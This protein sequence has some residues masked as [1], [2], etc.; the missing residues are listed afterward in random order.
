MQAKFGQRLGY[1]QLLANYMPERKS[2][3][4]VNQLVGSLGCTA[5]DVECEP[6]ED[7]WTFAQI[8]GQKCLGADK[9][10]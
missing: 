10:A 7:F 6:I 8:V 9:N 1:Y 2:R 5:G 4:S 3:L